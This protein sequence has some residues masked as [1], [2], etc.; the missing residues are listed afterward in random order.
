M[1]KDINL[2]KSLHAYVSVCVCVCFDKHALMSTEEDC[3][4]NKI[5]ILER[6]K[7]GSAM[8]TEVDW[9]SLLFHLKYVFKISKMSP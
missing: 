8:R 6:R 3:R 1:D 9:I 4:M 2:V 5:M 7:R